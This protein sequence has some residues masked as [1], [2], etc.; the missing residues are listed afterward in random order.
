MD[1]ENEPA[2]ENEARK[3]KGKFKIKKKLKKFLLPMLLAYKLKFLTL[4]PLLTGGMVLL[5]GSAG[6]AGFFFA[7]FSAVMGLKGSRPW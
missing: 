5:A 7:L 1:D 6:L 3:K 2:S 4:I